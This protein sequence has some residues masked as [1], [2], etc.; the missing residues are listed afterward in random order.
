MAND[1]FEP[2]KDWLKAR[3]TGENWPWQTD[4]PLTDDQQR[5]VNANAALLLNHEEWKAHV[6]AFEAALAGVEDEEKRAAKRALYEIRFDSFEF[7]YGFEVFLQLHFP[8]AVSFYKVTFGEGAVSFDRATFGEGAVSF[9]GATFGEGTVS[10][11]G[12]R[13]GEGTVS[14]TGATFGEGA[15]SFDRAT[16]GEGNV[17]FD[18]A[19]FGEGNVSFTGATFGEGN[20]F[21]NGST[22]GEGN[23]FFN[24][25]TFGEGDVSFR[26]A[27]FGEGQVS[28]FA[29]KFHPATTMN[30]SAMTISGSLFVSCA[31]GS[32]VNFT[33][34][35]VGEV[36]SFAGSSFARVPDFRYSKLDRPPEVATMRVPP[37]DMAR[38]PKREAEA[39]NKKLSRFSGFQPAQA[40]PP[41]QVTLDKEDVAR[42][43]ALKAMAEQANDHEKAGEFFAYEMMA[44][45]GVETTSFAGLFVNSVYR[46]LSGYGQD[47]VRPLIWMVVSFFVFFFGYLTIA[48]ETTKPADRSKFIEYSPFAASLSASNTVPLLGSLF[49]FASVPKDHVSAYDRRYNELKKAGL[50]VDW[51]VR[52]SVLQSIIG[53][54]LLFLFLL[55]LRNRFRLR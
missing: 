36:A 42:Y 48:V 29:A 30:A 49:R 34:L 50:P 26:S 51:I 15:V 11:N 8:C 31:F 2:F 46:S 55:A 21:F 4:K 43:R 44:K 12:A 10:F 19:T 24:E 16:F 32:R 33:Q 6:D 53:G 14:F 20:V 22:F 37:P 52:L 13:F 45:R 7:P 1:P 28:F 47:Y 5:I 17:S 54:I 25:A 38:D 23:V 40:C 9:I 18:E 3:P 41:F 35:K 27:T 39:R